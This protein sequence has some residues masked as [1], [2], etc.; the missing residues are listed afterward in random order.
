VTK[1]GIEEEFHTVDLATRRLVSSAPVLLDSLP[2]GPFTAEFKESAVEIVTTAHT[3]LEELREELIRARGT[4]VRT[5]AGLRLGVIASGTAPSMNLSDVRTTADD[6]YGTIDTEYAEVGRT[7][8]TCGLHV[9][10]EIEDRDLAVRAM[11][12]VEPH[13]STLLALSSGSPYWAGRDTGYASWRHLLMDRLPTAGPLGP[14][15]SAREYDDVLATLNRAGV[16]RDDRM[17]YS[18]LRLSSHVPTLELR[19]CDSVADVEVSV[20]IAALYRAIVTRAATAGEE[21]PR[22]SPMIARGAMWRAA[23]SGLEGDLIDPVSGLTA[24]AAVVVR[25]LL[26]ELEPGLRDTGDFERARNTVEEL[27]ACG[28]G[29]ARQRAAAE[30]GGLSGVVDHVLARTMA[31]VPLTGSDVDDVPDAVR[32]G[33]AGVPR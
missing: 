27:L 22:L 4:L 25:N 18:P 7:W 24:P 29:A 8:V 12:W 19:I 16:M 33:Q 11:A 30:K 5:A 14:L 15:R 31:C 32:D 20:L 17:F 26:A 1:L 10:V 9:H 23:R 13:L 21:P 28:S 3:E 6:R 2:R